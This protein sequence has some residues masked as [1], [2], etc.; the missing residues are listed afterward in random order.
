MALREY[1]PREEE[2][3]LPQDEIRVIYRVVGALD[4][5]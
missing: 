1:R 2:F 5:R 4:L 3:S